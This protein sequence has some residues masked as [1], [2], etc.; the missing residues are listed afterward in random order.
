MVKK[1]RWLGWCIFGP[2]SLQPLLH[3]P[4][5]SNHSTASCV[6]TSL[7]RCIPLNVGPFY[8][9]TKIKIPFSSV[10]LMG[11][12]Q[13]QPSQSA[14]KTYDL[15]LLCREIRS[16]KVLEWTDDDSIVKFMPNRTYIFD[17]ET[18]CVGCD[19][20]NDTFVNVNIPLLVSCKVKLI[21][22]QKL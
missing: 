10:H 17:P 6:C 8:S 21:R 4:Y 12:T 16:N 11:Y 19:D 7:N 13:I 14:G 2:F 1:V 15:H 9:N 20:R 18:S 3:P 5:I 22:N